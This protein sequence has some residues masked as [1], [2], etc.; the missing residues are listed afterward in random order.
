MA[1]TRPG[2]G[3]KKHQPIHGNKVQRDP[4]HMAKT[5][6]KSKDLNSYTTPSVAG[7]RS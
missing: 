6:S 4:S 1:K 5:R 7:T 3:R 2:T